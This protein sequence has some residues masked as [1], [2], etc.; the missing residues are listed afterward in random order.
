MIGWALRQGLLNIEW[1]MLFA[2]VNEVE[3]EGYFLISKPKNFAVDGKEPE[4]TIKHFKTKK[5]A[6][7]KLKSVQKDN[8]NQQSGIVLEADMDG[9]LE[10]V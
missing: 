6:M 1:S 10:V 4:I 9:G 8:E 5:F 7:S 2:G 3:G